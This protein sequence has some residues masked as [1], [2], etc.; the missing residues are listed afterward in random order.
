MK[1]SYIYIA[2]VILASILI[3]GC[4]DT[5]LRDPSGNNPNKPAQIS[6]REIRA[7][8]GGVT[9]YYNLPDDDNLKY[10]VARYRL[11]DGHVKEAKASFFVDSLTV[12]GFAEPKEYDVEIM[13]VSPSEIYSDPMVVKVIP[14]TPPYLVA[15]ETMKTK[16]IFG[17]INLQF[18][19]NSGAE[20]EVTVLKKSEEFG[21]PTWMTIDKFVRTTKEVSYNVRP[22][23]GLDPV[24]TDFG[25][26]VKDRYSNRTDT[27]FSRLSPMFEQALDKSQMSVY[28]YD[29]GLNPIPGDV[30]IQH[31]NPTSNGPQCLY[32]D[33][34]DMASNYVYFT[35]SN[36]GLPQGV[37]LDFG[38]KVILS[39]IVFYCRNDNASRYGH[40]FPKLLKIYGSNSPSAVGTVIN[41]EGVT[42]PD[43]S[44]TLLGDFECIP[45]SGNTDISLVTAADKEEVAANGHT[46]NFE[47]AIAFRYIRIWTTNVWLTGNK[48]VVIS[49]IDPYGDYV[50]E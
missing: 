12:R 2:C 13:S 28:S 4:S 16:S 35:K 26:L 1:N 5:E 29:G 46:Y 10:V 49:E 19:N 27:I 6:I 20:L 22:A 37:S 44:W 41:D 3:G 40:S 39:R 31:M 50:E 14:D 38:K 21:A 45:P 15:R 36:T 24:P 30:W 33:R 32:D 11:A 43:D 34:R 8:S 48:F 25:I 7:F 17:G 47:D 42:V 18:E 23:T 9:I